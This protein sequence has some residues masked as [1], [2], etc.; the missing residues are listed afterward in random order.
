MNQAEFSIRTPSDSAL[1]LT[2]AVLIY[3][4]AVAA[5][6]RRCTRSRTWTVRR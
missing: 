6:W 4:G 2:Q 1:V 3:K 5:C